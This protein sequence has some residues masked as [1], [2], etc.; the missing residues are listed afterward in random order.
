MMAAPEQSL[1]ALLNPTFSFLVCG[2]TGIGKSTLI[3]ILIAKKLCKVN[4]PGLPG[5]N[6]HPCTS[7]MNVVTKKLNGV[8]INVW[9]SPGLEDGVRKDNDYLDKME[10]TCGKKMENIDVI[11]YC[12]DMTVSRIPA[13]VIAI[14]ALTERFGDEFWQKSVFVMTKGNAVGCGT[15]KGKS[16]EYHKNVYY[17]LKREL[18]DKLI[19]LKVSKYIAESVP[20]VVAGYIDVH[21][22][23]EDTDMENESRYLLYVS[24]QI[25]ETDPPKRHDFLPEMWVTCFHHIVNEK[26]RGYFW[27]FAGS[28]RILAKNSPSPALEKVQKAKKEKQVKD[29]TLREKMKAIFK[30]KEQNTKKSST[31]PGKGSALEAVKRDTE[32]DTTTEGGNDLEIRDVSTLQ[33][34]DDQL[35]RTAEGLEAVI[36]HLS[37]LIGKL[38]EDSKTSISNVAK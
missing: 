17:N 30:S 7:E 15:A 37:Q 31:N 14:K 3:N 32:D 25:K 35:N 26:A 18:C 8:V 24:D 36:K 2:K 33:L 27:D 34:D 29:K 4:D 9:D 12:T 5:G 13:E 28:D 21:D 16:R 19:D 20:A 38:D 1:D 6:F 10:T 22:E 11:L 23:A